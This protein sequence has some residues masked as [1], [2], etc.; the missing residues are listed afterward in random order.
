M[1][2]FLIKDQ[3]SWTVL[4]DTFIMDGKMKD[5]DKEK[6]NEEIVENKDSNKNKKFKK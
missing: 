5:W 3:P 2:F 4:R 6:T 1:I